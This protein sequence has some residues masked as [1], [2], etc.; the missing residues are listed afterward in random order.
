[1]A[2]FR[3]ILPGSRHTRNIRHSVGDPSHLM[4]LLKQSQRL[5]D[6]REALS[7]SLMPAYL[8]YR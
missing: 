7:S 2:A 3:N 5:A 8:A 6:F 4:K 1:M